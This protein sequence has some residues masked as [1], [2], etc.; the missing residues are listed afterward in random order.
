MIVLILIFG[1]LILLAGIAI[2]FNPQ[3]VFE[4]LRAKA[5][6]VEL[7][8]L[9]VGVRLIL[10]ALLIVHAAASKFPIVIEVIGWISIAA[11]VLLTVIGRQ[12]F[13]RLM[14]WALKLIDPLG[15]IVGIFAT[16]FGAFLI[17]AFV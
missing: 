8:V 15:R 2:S 9:A 4:F 6:R 16:V 5:E 7:Q 17:Y 1:A 12:K 14:S 10:G 11:A 3:R 13:I